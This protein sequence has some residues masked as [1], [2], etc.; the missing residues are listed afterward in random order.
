[1]EY[2]VDATGLKCPEPVMM[3]HAAIRKASSGDVVCL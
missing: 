3:L 1:M 2:Q